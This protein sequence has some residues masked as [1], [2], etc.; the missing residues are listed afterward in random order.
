MARQYL[1]EAEGQRRLLVD[2]NLLVLYVV[3]NVNP[4]RVARF[5]RT[6]KY[7]VGDYRLLSVVMAEFPEMWTVPQVMAEVSN[8]TGLDGPERALAREV[9]RAVIHDT[10]ESATS[11]RTA[12]D[13]AAFPPLGIT[14]AAIA[15]AAR[16]INCAVLTD[17]LPLYLRLLDQN[18]QAYNFTHLRA[19][20][21]IV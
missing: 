6:E 21:G 20:Y 3:G 16:Q 7:T 4:H 9:L 8:L 5:K 12:S 2:S 19:R 13:H 15:S 10:S 11:S 17:D 1:P 14:D 18:V